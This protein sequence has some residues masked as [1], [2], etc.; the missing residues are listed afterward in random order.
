[1]LE[2]GTLKICNASAGSGKTFFLIKNYLYILFN[3]NDPKKFKTNLVLTFNKKSCDDIKNHILECIKDFSNQKIRN[4]YNIFYNFIIDNCQLTKD[5]LYKRSKNIEKEIF[6]DFYTFSNS[7]STIDK[8]TYR[9]IRSFSPNLSLEMNSHNFLSKIVDNIIYKIKNSKKY[10]RNFIQFFIEEIKH[11]KNWNLRKE[12][13]NIAL[14]M[15]NENHFFHMKK[16]KNFSKENLIQLKHIIRKRTKKFENLCK[17]QGNKFFNFLEKKSIPKNCFIYSDIPNFFIKFL[18]ENIIINPFKKRIEINVKNKKIFSKNFIK[19]NKKKTIKLIRYI[20]SLY[21]E[22]KYLYEKNISSYILDKFFLKSINLLSIVDEINK[23]FTLIKR[24]NNILLKEEL[25]Q[26]LYERINHSLPKIYEKIGIQYKYYF[27]DEF[28][29]ISYMQWKNIEILI[30][31]SLSE[32]GSAI[33]V[34]DPKQSIYRWRGGNSQQFF[35]LIYSYST[36]YKKKLEILKYNFRS[37]KEIVKFNNSFYPFISKIFKCLIYKNLYKNA[38]QKIH[39]INDTGYVRLQLINAINR[40]KYRENIYKNVIIQIKKLLEKKY[41]FSDIAILVRTNEEG[42][43]LSDKLIMNGINVNTSI[44]FLIKNYFEIQIIINFLYFLKNPLDQEKRVSLIL[45]LIKSN[46]I[47]VTKNY[48]HNFI[49][50]I[51]H[52]PMEY[53]I[54]EIFFSL[55]KKKKNVINIFIE[56]K[57]YNKSIYDISEYIIDFFD[58]L[59]KNN[60]IYIY[61]FLDFV[62]RFTRKIGNSIIDF[63]K[64]W[65][66]NKD[67]IIISNNFKKSIRI[68]T[69]HKSKGLQFPVVILPFVDWN[70]YLNSEKIKWIDINPKLYM[71]I[72]SLFLEIKSYYKN[73]NSIREIYEK[74]LSNTI[75][76]NI[77]LLYVA[78]TRPTKQL[79]ILS[80]IEKNQSYISYYIIEF[81]KYY[82]MWNSKKY[83]Y[84]FQKKNY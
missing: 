30:E 33:V 53:F 28:Q 59:S 44:S 58:L 31:N 29:D 16:M 15:I 17:E 24:E 64:Y 26:V 3:S 1:M 60:L 83:N 76:D 72:N 25:N 8:F 48:I 57:L 70:L 54:K 38:K 40:K 23:E 4:K 20:I 45:L 11:G 74:I 13:Y 81:L 36:A 47:K 39:H 18:M 77:N 32:N 78:T 42:S 61:T 73:I 82:N 2:S 79:I 62:Y 66:D 71:G 14:I 51:I 27:I 68:M 56:N 50:K 34:G 19:E 46:I 9:I 63:L 69:I 67:N 22:T 10:Y 7:I 21:K 5:E 43:Y 55:K 12:I 37:C 6:S 65:E 80:K 84:S 75:F 49:K 41:S 35:H 52:L